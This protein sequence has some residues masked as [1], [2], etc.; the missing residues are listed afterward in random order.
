LELDCLQRD[1]REEVH[2]TGESQ[3]LGIIAS[4]E[5]YGDTTDSDN[6]QEANGFRTIVEGILHAFP[7]ILLGGHMSTNFSPDDPLFYVHHANVDRMWSFWQDYQDQDQLEYEDFEVPW[8]YEGDLLDEPQPFGL[9]EISW[10]FRMEW[11][12]EDTAE[13]WSIKRAYPTPRDLL[14]NRQPHVSVRYVN[15]YLPSIMSDFDPNPQW[16]QVAKDNVEIRCD[17]DRLH[18]DGS[19]RSLAVSNQ[20]KSTKKY[21]QGNNLRGYLATRK[22]HSLLPACYQRN[23]FTRARDRERWIYLC[24]T[25]PKDTSI[26]DRLVAMAEADCNE[27]WGMKDMM[28]GHSMAANATQQWIRNMGKPKELAA[29]ECFHRPDR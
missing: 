10:D 15:D 4:F 24:Q 6:E 25:L 9:D 17:H 11:E 5:Q 2:F 26:A 20:V 22:T 8:H 28:N 3:L 1:F 29:F 23:P 18:W 14:P 13:E 7:H 21:Y 27:R 16:F 12:E 19:S